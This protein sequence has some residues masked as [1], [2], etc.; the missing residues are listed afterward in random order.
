MIPLKKIKI[1][2]YLLVLFAPILLDSCFLIDSVPKPIFSSQE[3][4]YSSNVE[5]NLACQI[6]ISKN[7][8]KGNKHFSIYQC[9]K[10]DS[11]MAIKKKNIV[12][13]HNG[14]ETPIYALRIQETSKFKKFWKKY[15]TKENIDWNKI[16]EHDFS[17]F[18]FMKIDF[19]RK[20]EMGD[21]M[22]IVERDFP[23]EGDSVVVTI[24]TPFA[25]PK[26]SLFRSMNLDANLQFYRLKMEIEEKQKGLAGL[27]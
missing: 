11:T 25:V 18:A 10:G 3:F 20:V 17:I 27:R 6:G 14:I 21:S 22:E 4:A 26:E 16:R 23:H 5:N 24:K 12:V 13:R 15:W 19:K 8:D 7:D 1:A 9:L 2:S